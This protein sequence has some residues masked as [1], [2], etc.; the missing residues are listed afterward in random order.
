MMQQQLVGSS[1][2]YKIFNRTILTPIEPYLLSEYHTES[3]PLA[4]SLANVLHY[5]LHAAAA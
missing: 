1:I 2:Y 4:W 5:I 3:K